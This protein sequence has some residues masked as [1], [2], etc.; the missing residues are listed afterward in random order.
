MYHPDINFTEID[1]AKYSSLKK[2]SN[3]WKTLDITSLNEILTKNDEY[4]AP[5]VPYNI[6]DQEKILQAHE[7]FFVNLQ[8]INTKLS[9]NGNSGMQSSYNV[10]TQIYPYENKNVFLFMQLSYFTEDM[11]LELV[12]FI[13][14]LSKSNSKIKKI[15]THSYKLLVEAS[16]YSK[17][18]NRTQELFTLNTYK[19]DK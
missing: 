4:D 1:L 13:V 19:H 5:G 18:L 11:F 16:N 9:E 15:K 7:L 3:T 14:D 6:V 12:Y 8:D 17:N 10:I 2:Y